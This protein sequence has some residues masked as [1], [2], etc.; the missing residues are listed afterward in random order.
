MS[1]TTQPALPLNLPAPAYY[2][3]IHTL[4]GILPR[5]LADTPE[6][7]FARNQAAIDKVAAMLPVNANEADLAAQCVASRAQAEDVMRLLRVHDG[8]TKTVMRLNAQY[9]A[10]V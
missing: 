3:L 6:A 4:A 8:D 1:N 5:P 10:L 2:Q 7:L 9:A